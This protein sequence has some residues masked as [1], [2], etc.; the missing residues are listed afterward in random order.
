M[1]RS[2]GNFFGSRLTPPPPP[3]PKK[4]LGQVG[5][6]CCSAPDGSGGWCFDANFN[7]SGRCGAV[8]GYDPASGGDICVP[9]TSGDTWSV[10]W[11]HPNCPSGAA[12]PLPPPATPPPEPEPEPDTNFCCSPDGDLLIFTDGTPC[13]PGTIEI[14]KGAECVPF[15]PEPVPSPEPE[16]EP[17][18]EPPP[19]A[20]TYYCCQPGGNLIAITDVTQCPP[21][22][23]EV[24]EGTECPLPADEEEALACL[25]NGT[26]DLYDVNGQL[27]A[28]DVAEAD[29]P[30]GVEIVAV[31]DPRCG[32]A[33]DPD[34]VS[35]TDGELPQDIPA[36]GPT[37]TSI[38]KTPLSPLP[39]APQAPQMPGQGPF[40]S[41]FYPCGT[42]LPVSVRSLRTETLPSRPD[43]WKDQWKS[44]YS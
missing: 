15:G 41:Q 29:L 1:G 27:V 10:G 20:G 16:P 36:P 23:T 7:A 28:S 38:P 34:V 18:P 6:L 35:P 26:F 13:S 43:S 39:G 21:G 8:W 5:S 40:T 2:F 17:I 14:P 3:P 31:D 22:T 4:K 9:D 42:K 24:A 37:A 33:L 19:G 25:T 44:L 30:A 12:P 11:V 32:P